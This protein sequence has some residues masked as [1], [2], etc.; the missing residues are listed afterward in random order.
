MIWYDRALKASIEKKLLALFAVALAVIAAAYIYYGN[1]FGWKIDPSGS[2]ADWGVF[3]DFIGGVTNPILAFLTFIGL[4]WNLNIASKQ[5]EDA[6]TE[7]KR[8]EA[9]EV[10]KDIFRMIDT[11]A[12]DI[13]DILQHQVTCI[14]TETAFADMIMPFYNFVKSKYTLEDAIW[15]MDRNEVYIDNVV[16][17]ILILKRYL[18][19]YSNVSGND[20]VIDYYKNIYL[21]LIRYLTKIDKIDDELTN[22]FEV[23]TAIAIE[24]E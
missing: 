20:F 7:S 6:K 5:V 21:G 17:H 4:L 23:R 9:S 14:L 10:R 22:F 19:E 1:H 12:K 3:G 24:I 8:L 15:V 18:E 13:N 2:K 16:I 11:I